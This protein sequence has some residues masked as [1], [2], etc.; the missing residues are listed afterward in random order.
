MAVR[1]DK[2]AIIGA[3]HVGA[4]AAYALMLRG[5]FTDIVLIDADSA[6]AQAEALDIADANALARPAHVRHG[7]YA[8]AGDAAIVVITAGAS[9]QGE[10]SRLSVAGRSAA[11]VADCARRVAEAGFAGVMIV[12]SNPVDAMAQV[13]QRASGLPTGQVIGTGTLLD[14]A[15]F[16][17]RLADR[18]GVAPVSVEGMVLG[19]HGDSEVAVFSGVRIGGVALDQLRDGAMLDRAELARETMRAGYAIAHGKGHTSYGVATA[20]VRLCEAVRRDEQV[21]LPVSTLAQGACGV[22]GVYL[23]LPCVIGALGVARV[24][25]PELDAR[26]ADALRRSATILRGIMAELDGQG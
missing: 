19:E 2:V 14:S 6:R 24:L 11:I 20:I 22:A 8:E 4:T 21:V 15:R 7:D 3:G 26:E 23:S 9:P 13:A 16:R 25:A 12:A 1:F 5:L 10:E 18:L 17:R